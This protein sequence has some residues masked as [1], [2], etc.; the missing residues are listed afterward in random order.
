MLALDLGILE[1]G[2]VVAVDQAA[3]PG[4]AVFLGPDSS[5]LAYVVADPKRAGVYVAKL[6]R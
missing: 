4:S 6:P 1:K 3:L 5:R 2:R